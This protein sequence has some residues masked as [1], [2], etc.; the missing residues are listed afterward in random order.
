ML[1]AGR[2]NFKAKLRPY[3]WDKVFLQ[4][5]HVFFFFQSNKLT[6]VLKICLFY[7]FFFKKKKKFSSA[8][9]IEYMLF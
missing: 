8:F 2:I 7:M 5:V 4:T 3:M 1:G 9:L 6:S